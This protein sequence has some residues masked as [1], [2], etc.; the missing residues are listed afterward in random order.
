MGSTGERGWRQLTWSR[1]REWLLSSMTSQMA[2]QRKPR[3]LWFAF[4]DTS[5]PFAHILALVNA[6]VLVM[7]MVNER[8]QAVEN[9]AAVVPMT[10]DFGLVVGRRFANRFIC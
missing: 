10:S 1:T 2:E 6:D 4:P 9:L 8:L 7:Q 5:S 3:S